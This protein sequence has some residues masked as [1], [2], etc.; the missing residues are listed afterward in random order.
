MVIFLKYVHETPFLY[1]SLA[2]CPALKNKGGKKFTY[3]H[4]CICRPRA[5]RID[6]ML[7]VKA[8]W[9]LI[10]HLGV[11]YITLNILQKIC[12]TSFVIRRKKIGE[13]F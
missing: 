12:T 1:L 11:P 10:Y 7:T 8:S 9:R 6:N 13:H 4:I 3:S 2:P 5:G